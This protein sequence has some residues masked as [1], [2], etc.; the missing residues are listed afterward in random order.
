MN[1]KLM[2]TGGI[3]GALKTNAVAEVRAIRV[4][5]G[6]GDEPLIAM[7][8]AH[9]ALALENIAYADSDVYPGLIDDVSSQGIFIAGILGRTCAL[10]GLGVPDFVG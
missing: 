9:P 3:T 4:R 5:L 2:K 6:C 7:A 1:L 10:P 8:V